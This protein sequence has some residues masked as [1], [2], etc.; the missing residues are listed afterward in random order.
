MPTLYAIAAMSEN[1]VI[2]NQGKLPWDLPEE[3]AWFK[4]RT[5]GGTLII[6][7]KTFKS[8]GDHLTDW[9]KVVLSRSVEVPGVTTCHDITTLDETLRPLPKPYWVCGGVEVY[10]HLLR[11]CD[12]LYLTRIKRIISGDAFFPPFEDKFEIDQLIHEN[13]TFRVE[14]WRRLFHSE[15]PPIEPEPWPFEQPQA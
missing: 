9:K 10:R 15:R 4:H 7:R 8:L 3:Y 12:I 11:N 2:G 5:M 14:R 1:R 13:E 6:G